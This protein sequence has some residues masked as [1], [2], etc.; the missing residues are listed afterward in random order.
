MAQ[1]KALAITTLVIAIVALVLAGVLG[2]MSLGGI[3]GLKGRVDS[4]E[5]S[6]KENA[7][8]IETLTGTVQE[9]EGKFKVPA[10]EEGK[11]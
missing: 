6:L 3:S 1:G 2:Y 10:I 9:L 7:G 4:L 11:E 8:K 5:V